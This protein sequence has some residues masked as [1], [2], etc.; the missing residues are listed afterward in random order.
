MFDGGTLKRSHKRWKTPSRPLGHPHYRPKTAKV[1][2][3]Q[4]SIGT[5][6]HDLDKHKNQ[7]KHLNVDWWGPIKAKSSNQVSLPQLLHLGGS[8]TTR[9]S[10]RSRCAWIARCAARKPYTKARRETMRELKRPPRLATQK[11]RTGVFSLPSD[12]RKRVK[13]NRAFFVQIHL[14][15]SHIDTN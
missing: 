2:R 4:V 10:A 15:L 8:S 1:M 7:G 12:A 9:Q 13:I 3:I 11:S 6:R 5:I 14:L